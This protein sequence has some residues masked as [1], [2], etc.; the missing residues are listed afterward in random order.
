[1]ER[2]CGDLPFG[3][4]LNLP[5]TVDLT[6][7]YGGIFVFWS[8]FLSAER[9]CLMNYMGPFADAVAHSILALRKKEPHPP[10]CGYNY[11]GAVIIIGVR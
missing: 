3:E 5:M 4:Y 10:G 1:M 6:K 2:E 9:P 11:R 8:P 7:I